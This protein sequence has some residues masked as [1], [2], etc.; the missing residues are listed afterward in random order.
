M[1]QYS[2]PGKY[3][4]ILGNQAPIEKKKQNRPRVL[5]KRRKAKTLPN[6]RVNSQELHEANRIVKDYCLGE[7]T[8]QTARSARE[9]LEK[10]HTFVRKG[11][12]GG[13]SKGKSK[14]NC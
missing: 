11:R 10:Q 3:L 14:Q 1:Q 2:L 7:K 12:G 13:T 9:R 4:T 6:G 5:P 8:Q